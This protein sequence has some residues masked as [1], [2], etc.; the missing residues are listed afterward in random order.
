ML[1][2]DSADT[3]GG[4]GIGEAERCSNA[5]AAAGTGTHAGE[6]E[7]CI[8]RGDAEMEAG[9]AESALGWYRRAA[10]ADPGD[11]EVWSSA[12]EALAALG[13]HAAASAAY[14]QAVLAEPA[15]PE[16]HL[17]RARQ[18]AECGTREAAM[19]SI[20]TA[21]GQLQDRDSEGVGG[22]G[23]GDPEAVADCWVELGVAAF[24][25]GRTAE[26]LDHYARALA[27]AP[28]HEWAR[29]TTRNATARRHMEVAAATSPAPPAS[30]E[31]VLL[32]QY[33]T[34]ALPDRDG[35]TRNPLW[36]THLS[37]WLDPGTCAGLVRAAERYVGSK[38]G[39]TSE[40]HAGPTATFD[41]EVTE[42]AELWGWAAPRV[43]STILPTMSGL[44]FPAGGDTGRETPELLLREFFCVKYEAG[45]D[46]L[47]YDGPGRRAGLPLHRDGYLLSFSILLNPPAPCSSG[48]A[49]AGGD[50][51]AA[52]AS[53][54][55]S[56]SSSAAAGGN[57]GFEGGGT[58][59]ETLDVAVCPDRVGDVFMHSGRMLHGGEPVTKGVRY[60]LIGFVE[61]LP[62]AAAARAAAAV[63]GTD[64]WTARYNTDPDDALAGVTDYETLCKEW[65]LLIG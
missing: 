18:L 22:G 54:S 26:A 37:H 51:N 50:S 55:S 43:H 32:R 1:R 38:G 36:A 23:G 44:F 6:A 28:G 35:F 39:W 52:A 15:D 9:E 2:G 53:S 59:L 46:K 13:R 45:G 58:R 63:A 47:G 27:C 48:D 11:W 61:A 57:G 7:R 40:R 25:L 16:L 24:D 34:I 5:D 49:G 62:T 14:G 21:L 31:A 29:R 12:G 10:V 64:E 4:T 20:R 41:F 3:A 42:C 60:L 8:A 30:F 56:S 17:L 33:R 19:A 65:A